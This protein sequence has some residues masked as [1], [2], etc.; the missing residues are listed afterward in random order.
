MA[1]RSLKQ[2]PN[3]CVNADSFFRWRSKSNRLRKALCDLSLLNEL[4]VHAP[5][6]NLT[7]HCSIQKISEDFRLWA[8]RL[9]ESS[10]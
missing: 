3:N 2:S 4:Q 7:L 8:Q 9:K 5:V 6:D 10:L 1:D